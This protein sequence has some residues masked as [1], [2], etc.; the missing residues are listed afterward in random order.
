MLVLKEELGEERF[1]KG[2]Y[3]TAALLMEK[4][5]TSDELADFLT[6]SSYSFLD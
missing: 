1:D 3:A 5:T 6:L 2:Q 4:L